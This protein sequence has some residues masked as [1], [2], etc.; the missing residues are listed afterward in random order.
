[1][2]SLLS[3]LLAAVEVRDSTFEK[4]SLAECLKVLLLES[5]SLSDCFCSD[6]PSPGEVGHSVSSSNSLSNDLIPLVLWSL[7]CG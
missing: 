3:F 2:V 7:L 4:S 5:S 6:A 1:M